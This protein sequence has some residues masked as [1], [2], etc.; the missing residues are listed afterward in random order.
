MTNQLTQYNHNFNGTK[1]QVIN[2]DGDYWLTATQIGEALGYSNARLSIGKLF[3]ANKELLSDYSVET[4]LVST[5]GKSYK[6]RVFNQEGVMLIDNVAN[7]SIIIGTY[8]KK[9]FSA[10]VSPAVFLRLFFKLATLYGRLGSAKYPISTHL[11][12][13]VSQDLPPSFGGRKLLKTKGGQS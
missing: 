2:K 8:F 1:I 12:F 13:E 9:R 7:I 10:L 5:D 3:R 11:L 4:E 6:Q